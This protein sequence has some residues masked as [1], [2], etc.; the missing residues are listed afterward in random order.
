MCSLTSSGENTFFALHT[1]T[2]I[3]RVQYHNTSLMK[4]CRAVDTDM[5]TV[6]C[7]QEAM[8]GGDR[9]QKITD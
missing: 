5:K 9:K 6:C 4:T 3:S 2:T 8:V 1:W 7:F